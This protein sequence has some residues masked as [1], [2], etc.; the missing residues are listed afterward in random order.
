VPKG[1]EMNDKWFLV[2]QVVAGTM[3][4][5]AIILPLI[6]VVVMSIWRILFSLAGF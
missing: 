4:V 3:F 1:I 5:A 6:I 2:L